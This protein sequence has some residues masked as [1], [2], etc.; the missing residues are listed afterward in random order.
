MQ[1]KGLLNISAS[2]FTDQDLEAATHT[3][4]LTPRDEII[5][6]V[7]YG[8]SGLGNGS[9]G[10]GVLPQ[11]MLKESEYRYGFVMSAI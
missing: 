7:D 3:Y 9:C 5:F 8:K 11:Y 4:E 10:P 6:N 2:H 1:G